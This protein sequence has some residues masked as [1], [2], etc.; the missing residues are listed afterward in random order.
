MF[1]FYL[2][3]FYSYSKI[4]LWPLSY[5]AKVYTAKM[6]LT[7]MLTAKVPKIACSFESHLLNSEAWKVLV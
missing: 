5:S 2:L 7:K 3:L 4:A 6:S 1:L